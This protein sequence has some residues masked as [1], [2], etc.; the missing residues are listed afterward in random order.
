MRVKEVEGGMWHREADKNFLLG[1]L[2]LQMK[3][4]LPALQHLQRANHLY[5][6]ISGNEKHIIRMV[7]GAIHQVSLI[8][9]ACPIHHSVTEGDVH[10]MSIKDSSTRRGTL[11][12]SLVHVEW[13][14]DLPFST[15]GTP[16]FEASKMLN[17][18]IC[19]QH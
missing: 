5:R 17:H 7:A 9:M 18:E 10:L 6:N 16:R 11:V 3:H 12:A 15:C 19:L 1:L 4:R 13:W 8:P 2:H 14:F